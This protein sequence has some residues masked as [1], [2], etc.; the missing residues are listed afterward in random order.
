MPDTK[1]CYAG[2]D[3]LKNRLGIADKDRL[4][5]AE[6]DLATLRLLELQIHPVKGRFDFGNLKS[7][8]R[9]IFQD[10]YDWAGET[11]TVNIGKGYLFCLSQYIDGFAE[12]IFATFAKDCFAAKDSHGKFVKTLAKY[13]GDM[14]ALHPFRE[15]NG[16]SQREFARELCLACGYGFDL[17][18]TNHEDMLSASIASFNKEDNSYFESIFSRAVQPI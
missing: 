14:N 1:Y 7:I 6:T 3:V 17:S 13:Y 8:H 16:R 10:L 18:F 15:G 4:L 9:H 5:R 2:S 11:R 12:S